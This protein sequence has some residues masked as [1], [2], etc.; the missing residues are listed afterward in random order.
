MRN[1]L[2]HIGLATAVMFS[3]LGGALAQ[4]TDGIDVS[5]IR[6]RTEEGQADAE[7]LAIMA[8][9]RA[10]AL[11][12]HARQSAI[13]ARVH[14]Q[15]YARS[16]KV[17]KATRDAFDFDRMVSQSSN[18]AKSDLGAAPRFIAFA[19]LSMPRDA[20]RQMMEDV[21][22]AGGAVVFRGLTRGSASIMTQGLQRV[23][24][25][26]AQPD[27][28]GI[29][30]RLFRAFGITEVPAYVVASSDFDLC[31]GFDCTDDVPPF[32]IVRGN[33]TAA[34]ALQRMA[35]GGGPGARIAAQHLVRLNGEAP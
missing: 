10:G 35:D 34:F 29:D 7:A 32:D 1:T 17:T 27:G 18:M 30:P 11:T 25:Q 2:Q 16:I 20:L 9:A 23:L 22:R 8:R 19:S 26:G 12:E 31:A 6:K 15:S 24:K 33:V 13:E 4:S 28:V 21:P 3:A 5:A 14:G